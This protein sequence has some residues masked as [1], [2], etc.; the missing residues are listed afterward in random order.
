M[1]LLF[2]IA[3]VCFL[4]SSSLVAENDHSH[5]LLIEPSGNKVTY[6]LDSV[7]IPLGKLLDAASE[8]VVNKES[9]NPVAIIF[10]STIALD[11]VLNAQGIFNKAGFQKVALFAL[12]KKTGKMCEVSLGPPI[13][14]KL[15]SPAVTP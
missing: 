15:N 1:T 8:M 12:W 4:L 3:A 13:P 2:K 6:S 10:D 14:F 7:D 5:T 11:V 9:Q